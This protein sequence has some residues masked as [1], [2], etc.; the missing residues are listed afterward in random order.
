MRFLACS[1][2]LL[3]VFNSLFFATSSA[4]A[5]TTWHVDDDACP[6]PGS[7]T[8][9]DPFCRIQ[10]AIDDSSDGDEV[11]VQP[12]TYIE[13]INFLGK[14]I[15]VRSL[16][17]TD[18]ASVE[19]TV[20]DGS[21]PEPFGPGTV[22][23][24]ESGEGNDSV[25]L[26]FT[27]TNASTG[28]LGGGIRCSGSDATIAHC[29]ITNNSAEIGGGIGCSSSS[30]IVINSIIQDN[31]ALVGG[32]LWLTG[33]SNPTITNCLISGNSVTFSGGG[34]STSGSP[35]IVNCTI[36]DNTASQRGGG[37]QFSGNGAMINCI[38]WGNQASEGPQIS[39]VGLG[40]LAVQYSDVEGGESEVFVQPG[41]GLE[42]GPGNI[43]LDPQFVDPASE[44]Y[45]PLPGSPCIDAGDNTAVPPYVTTDLEANPRF[46]DDPDTPDTGKPDGVNP[47]VDM[48]A[49]EFGPRDLC[50]D[51]N[52]DGRVTICHVPP[53]NPDN[54]RTIIVNENAVPAHLAHGDS[55]GP[56]EEHGGAPPDE[57][58]DGESEASACPADV[59]GD[60]AVSAA[61]LALLLGSSG[62]CGDQDDCP[63]DLDGS[64]AVG[65]F[66]LALL[67]GS[68]GPC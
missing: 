41:P 52:G 1:I 6:G 12:G 32:G 24:F 37:I 19:A 17:P 59:D 9:S 46:V 43:D 39:L 4:D 68:W 10:N 60:S 18:P 67:L 44:H 22:V 15:T 7:G 35:T 23:T 26:G 63:A 61:D 11:V 34:I 66:D 36:V 62:P 29:V 31:F 13:N 25:L 57:G 58:G 38:L 8:E 16:N 53:G 54:A 5:Q 21:E 56:C 48:G 40:P 51:D 55:C 65:P 42:W 27:V 45:H 33:E 28:S 50:A 47:L 64:G 2:S 30:P 49:Y 14:A 3:F 20:I